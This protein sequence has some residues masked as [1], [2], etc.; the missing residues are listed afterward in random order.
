MQFPTVSPLVLLPEASAGPAVK[1]EADAIA[2]TA[3][4]NLIRI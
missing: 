2:T 4:D 3:K 1:M